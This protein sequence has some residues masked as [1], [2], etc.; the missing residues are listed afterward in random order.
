MSEKLNRAMVRILS[1]PDYTVGGGVLVGER[2]I[3]T[4][5]HVVARAIGCT[6]FEQEAPQDFIQLEFPFI[7]PHQVLTATVEFWKAAQSNI[8]ESGAEDI[9]VLKLSSPLPKGAESITLRHT[10]DMSGHNFEVFGF[11]EDHNKEGARVRGQI[12]GPLRNG[13]VQVE[14]IRS[15]GFQI[16][17]GYSGS[18]VWNRDIQAVVGI[19]VA[20]DMEIPERRVGYLIPTKVLMEAWPTLTAWVLPIKASIK[21][22]NEALMVSPFKYTGPLPK[23]S[24]VYIARKC[25]EDL[26]GNLKTE[27]LIAIQGDFEVGKSSLLVQVCNMSFIDEY[28]WQC[29]YIDLQ[30][31]NTENT[32]I[33]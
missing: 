8:A 29:C 25:D 14:G 3:L 1:S 20:F 26:L 7:T 24:E 19:T 13:K 27:K 28:G 9:A 4:C 32:E 15:Q 11:P 10:S 23:D 16:E 30:G 2:Y 18:P 5:A 33:F 6:V 22:W 21:E 17:P 31:I 12:V